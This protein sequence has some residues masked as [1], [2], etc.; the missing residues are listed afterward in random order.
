M[1]D[2]VAGNTI[3]TRPLARGTPHQCRAS[4]MIARRPW[5]SWVR[6]VVAARKPPP[7]P[8]ASTASPAVAGNPGWC[9]CCRS[10][11][12]FVETGAWLRDQ[13]LCTRCK[14][15]PRFR[16]VNLALDTYFPSWEQARIHESS[17]CNDFIRRYCEHYSF[18][19][20]FE[21][22][23]LGTEH[24]GARCEDLERLTFPD[25]TFDLF[26]TQDVLE[27]VFQPDRAIREI[28]RVIKPGGAHVFTAPKHRGLGRTCQRA[29][30]DRGTIVHLLEAQYHGSPVGDGRALVTWDYGDDFELCLWQWCR[31][32][33]VTYVV[34]DRGLGLDGEYLEVFVT[35]K[36]ASPTDGCRL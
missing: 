31:F 7:R 33:T 19:Y 28:M 13:Y 21:E 30:V 1:A 25:E 23:P 9:S 32:P 22:V 20:F 24:K 34:R 10:D 18:S 4:A 17:P 2:S 27:H 26:I 36:I 5:L 3:R 35:R 6:R 8:T 12:E 29:R 14:S 16:A 11:S 15:I